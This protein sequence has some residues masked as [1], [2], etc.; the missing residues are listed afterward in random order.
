MIRKWQN[1]PGPMTHVLMDGGILHVDNLDEFYKQYIDNLKTSKL[2]VVEQKT[3]MFRF[4]IDMDYKG[5]KALESSEIIRLVKIMNTVTNKRAFIA[6]TPIRTLPGGIVKTGVHIHWPDLVVNKQDAI[7]LRN[8][9][10]MLIPESNEWIDISVYGGSGLRMI[11]SHKR[12][13]D[14]DRPPYTPWRT[15]KGDLVTPLPQEPALDTLKLFCIRTDQVRSTINK[16]IDK[17]C[18]KLEEYINKYMDGQQYAR[19]LKVFKTK[20]DKSLCVQTDSRFCE[21]VSKSHRRNHIWFWIKHGK[22]RQM[23]LDEDCKEFEGGR[24]YNLPPSIL[25]ELQDDTVA[26]CADAGISFRD[27]FSLH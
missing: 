25:K 11:W 15:I 14:I 7:K 20:T 8:Q 13:G 3:E 24:E 2:Y 18:S 4:F 19:V 1:M 17:D 16:S 27:A 26:E 10:V 22:I 9:I 6:L 23:C 12:E 5:D 21:N